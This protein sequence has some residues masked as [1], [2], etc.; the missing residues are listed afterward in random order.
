MSQYG[1]QAMAL[2]GADYTEILLHYYTGV[3]I[4]RIDELENTTMP[5]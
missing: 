5:G 4:C 3:R 1:A 2:A